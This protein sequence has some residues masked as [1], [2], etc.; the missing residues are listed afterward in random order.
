MYL[1]CQL[2][3]LCANTFQILFNSATTERAFSVSS[4]TIAQQ[5]EEWKRKKA[6]EKPGFVWK[7]GSAKWGV[8]LGGTA[9]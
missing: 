9:V 4:I 2:T 6:K 7:P 8:R 3:N 5:K 1:R